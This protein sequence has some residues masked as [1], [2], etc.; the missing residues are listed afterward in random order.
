MAWQDLLAA[1][2]LMLVFE[3]ILPFLNPARFRNMLRM[4]DEMDDSSVRKIGLVSMI[5]GLVL[6]YLGK[7]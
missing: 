5:A 1:L 4:L 2:A 3:G 7:L 6:L